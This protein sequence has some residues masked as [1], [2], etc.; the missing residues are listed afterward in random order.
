M[1]FM[2]TEKYWSCAQKV[3]EIEEVTWWAQNVFLI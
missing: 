2:G 1:A 3:V